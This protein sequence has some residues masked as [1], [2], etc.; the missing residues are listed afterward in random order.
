MVIINDMLAFLFGKLMGRHKLWELS[1]KKTVEGFIGGMFGTIAL[2][3]LIAKLCSY[4]F[5]K[6]VLCP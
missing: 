5:M 1:P 6:P 2:A 3:A 4:E